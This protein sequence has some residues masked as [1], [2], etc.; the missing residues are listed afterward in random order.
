[1]GN[2]LDVL[3][4][5][6]GRNMEGTESKGKTGK[7]LNVLNVLMVLA[8]QPARFGLLPLSNITV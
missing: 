3:M 8:C 6:V 4:S 7:V 2:V 5:R 1:M